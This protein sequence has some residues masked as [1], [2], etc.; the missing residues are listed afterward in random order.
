MEVGE[1]WVKLGLDK[2]GFDNGVKDAQSKSTGLGGF[3]KNAFQ[4]TVGAGMFDLL[5]TGIKSAWDASIGFNSQMQQSNIAF[6]TMLGSADKANKLLGQLSDFAAK[7]PFEFPDLTDASKKMLAFG[8]NSQQ[9]MPMLKSVGD[10][11]SGLGMSGKE[12]LDRIIIALGQTK[13]AGKLTGD[14]LR[15]LT[16]AGVPVWDIL[17]KGFNTTTANMQKMVSKG[18]VPADKGIQILISG[19]EQR[20]PNMMD[21]QSKSFSGLMSTLKDTMNITLGNM[22][23][24]S[25]NWLTETALPKAINLVNKFGEG[26]KTGGLQGALKA[27]FPPEIAPIIDGIGNAIKFLKEHSEALKIVLIAL[28]GAFV[29][30]KA[31]V[32]ASIATQEIGNTILLISTIRT[33]GLAAAQRLFTKET[34]NATIAQKLLNLV[35]NMNPIGIAIALI[36]AAVAALIY[37]WKTNSDFR[38][39]IIGCWN[40]IKQVASTVWNAISGIFITVA[41]YIVQNVVTVFNNM[42]KGLTDIWNGIKLVASGVWQLIK[43]VIL[44][45]VLLICDLITGNWKKLGSD[46][47]A[48]WQSLC[49]AVGK[50]FGGLGTIIK[51]IGETIFGLVKGAFINIINTVKTIWSKIGPTVKEEFSSAL[52]F[53]KNLPGEALQWGKDMVHGFINGIKSL[54]GEIED[55]AKFAANK[56][57]S[58]LHFSKPDKGPLAD[59]DKY[60][61]DFMKLLADTIDANSDKPAEAAKKVAQL[62]SDKIKSIKDSLS[63]DTK[64]LN[65]QL[66]QLNVDENRALR[67]V[68]GNKR[69]NIEDEYT[70][71]KASVKKQLDLRKEQAD[72][73]I[74]EIQRIGKMNK[75]E[76]DKELADKKAFVDSV[77]DLNSSIKDALK[78]MYE[79][80]E[81]AQEDSINNELNNL[82]KWK[83][84]QEN[85]INSVYTA[86]ENAINDQ[87]DALDRQQTLKDRADQDTSDNSSM[88]YLQ[89]RIN[90]STD[91]LERMSLE[92]QIIKAQSELEKR[93]NKEKLDDEKSVLQ[94]Q[95]DNLQQQK[96][97]E[98]DNIT[99]I[100]DAKKADLDQQLKDLKTFYDTRTSDAVLETQAERLIM[101]NNQKEIVKLLKSYGKEYE[102][103]GQTLGDRLIAGFAPKIGAIQSMI[104]NITASINSYANSSMSKAVSGA[105]GSIT[106]AARSVT[107]HIPHNA[108]GTNFWQGGL[109]WVN[110]NGP[111]LINLP[112]GSQVIPNGKIGNEASQII[113]VNV[114]ADDL[115]SIA[116]VVKLFEGFRQMSRK[117]V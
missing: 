94:K 72:K 20:F 82:E 100:Y 91:P 17:A 87:I 90:R 42:K 4:F 38:N 69:Y 59:A 62:V 28:V 15:Q 44:G 46:S 48:L 70:A 81:K 92:Q 50:I 58:F 2:S 56:I 30:H 8:F 66:S 76:L 108:L 32:L 27:T 61:Y 63:K 37:L 73:E 12:G 115:Q 114:N 57:R 26:F 51:G 6:T 11:A 64:N 89:D 75:D 105:A 106:N 74:A 45:P 113:Y 112:R 55:G 22:M 99:A 9:I 77:N 65:A 98:L 101:D 78:S 95:K 107:S 35:M 16:E 79:A 60:G 3:I 86:R 88:A 36:G 83:T 10:A 71:K 109:T 52:N 110:E 7:T 39:F 96:Q 13:A 54:G 34:Q 117:G 21:K 23:K 47:K 103:A 67:G 29:A 85:A 84:A 68:K 5:K 25:F 49:S 14:N 80:Q 116:D 93:H 1:L 33:G 19:M 43:T 24:S 41:T 97:A 18:I 53:F 111:E 102:V 104:A 40:E 31:A